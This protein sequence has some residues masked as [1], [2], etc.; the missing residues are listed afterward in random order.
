VIKRIS[1]LSRVELKN[2]FRAIVSVILIGVLFVLIRLYDPALFNSITQDVINHST[3]FGLLRWGLIVF[4]I[5]IWPFIVHSIGKSKAA[6]SETIA[7]WKA[8]VFRVAAW[9]SIFELLVC[10]NMIGK[11]IHLL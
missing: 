9:L 1:L 11:L 8:E 10:E 3:V 7:Y 2:L 5:V 6:R 4:I